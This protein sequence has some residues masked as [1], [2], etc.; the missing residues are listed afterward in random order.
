MCR[1]LLGIVWIVV[2]LQPAVLTG[3]CNRTADS[4]A[5]VAIYTNCTGDTWTNKTNWLV[6][7]K[8]VSS[9]FGIKVN[10]AGCVE[11][12]SMPTNKMNGA[13]PDETG[14]LQALKILNLTNNNLSGNLPVSIGKLTSLE[15]VNLSSNKLNGPIHASF[16][17]LVKLRKLQLSLNNFS[18][19]LPSALGA[20]KALVIF[21]VNQNNLNGPLP[22]AMGNM[23]N[24]E[25]L[26]L[27]QNQF[28]G[29]LPVELGNLTRLRSLIISQNGFSGNLPPELGKLSQLQF[30][31]ADENQFA[32]SIPSAWSGMAALKELW[33]HKNRLSGIIPAEMTSIFS[34]QKLLLNENQLTGPIPDQMGNLKS[35]ISLHLSDNQLSGSLPPSLGNMTSMLSFLVNNNALTGA[36]PPQLGNCTNLSSLNLANNL[37]DG[38]LPPALGKLASLKRFYAQNNRFEGCFP[39]SFQRFCTLGESSN[40]NANGYNFRNNAR[41]VF[42][43][44]FGRWCNGEGRAKAVAQANTPL[45]EG[46]ELKLVGSGGTVFQWSGPAAFQS[47]LASPTIPAIGQTQFGTYILAVENENKCRDTVRLKIEQT[48]SVAAA[49]SGPLCEGDTIKLSASGGISYRWS[50]PAGFVSTLQNPR[51]ANAQPQMEGEYS[52][53]IT[54]A[55]CVITRKLPISFVRTS[56]LTSNSPLCEGDTLRLRVADGASFQWAGPGGYAGQQQDAVIPGITAS[57]QGIYKVVVLN[58]AGCR[59]TLA[60]TVEVRV[61]QVPKVADFPLV[62]QQQEPLVLPSVVDG[63]SG[64]WKG[65]GI[66]LQQQSYIFDPSGLAG[67]QNIVFLPASVS[68][69]ITSATKEIKVSVIDVRI[70]SIVPSANGA[71]TDG[72]VILQ[73]ATNTTEV[74]LTFNGP[75]S[76][77]KTVAAFQEYVLDNLPSGQYLI[78]VSDASSCFDTASVY[79]PYVRPSS[80][81]PNVVHAASNTGNGQFYLSGENIGTYTLEVYNRWGSLVFE[82]N[83]LVPGQPDQGWQPNAG[84]QGVYVWRITYTTYFGIKTRVGSVTVL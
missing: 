7:G 84:Q 5:L 61:N 15:E 6:P 46:S 50:G 10:A 13:L 28:I 79:V 32:G 1:L 62:C 66:S 40:P 39:I 3:Q 55:D 33:L 83:A 49:A 60:D 53:E 75:V 48:G 63:F 43:G 34:L 56:T 38:E 57:K 12:I 41:L 47:N 26:L 25:E 19:N 18:G 70:D 68:G 45:C 23:S 71:D 82:G 65:P 14:N 31:Y 51:I 20:M 78:A 9:W 4:L 76:G 44:D 80:Y 11:S 58:A 17:N 64:T 81:L 73:L 24:L 69:C 72:K 8:P 74:N 59:F 21:H 52:V 29:S 77:S 35:M 36:I 42:S 37:L 27:S 22:P 30:F 54:T 16:G 2:C 67:V